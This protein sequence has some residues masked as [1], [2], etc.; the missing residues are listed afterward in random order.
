MRNK[1]PYSERDSIT[2]QGGEKVK[3]TRARPCRGRVTFYFA[4]VT[5]WSNKAVDYLVEQD[6]AFAKA[7]V[8]AIVEHHKRGAGLTGAIKR[9]HKLGWRVTAAP[10][11]DTGMAVHRAGHGHGGVWVQTRSHLQQSGLTEES[12][13][14]VQKDEHRGLETQWTARRVRMQGHDVIFA[15]VYLAPGEGLQG[16]NHVTLQEVG[17]Y[18]KVMGAPFIL[19]GDFNMTVEELMPYGMHTFLTADWRSPQR[20]HQEANEASTSC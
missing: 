16:A 9:L 3:R 7:D 2:Y 19:A 13:T 15:A 4:N 1:I 10:C 20:R 8:A 5:S 18:L 12:K 14:A 11:V 6:S 17:T